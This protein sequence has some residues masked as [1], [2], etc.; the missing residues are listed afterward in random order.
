MHVRNDI[1][2]QFDIPKSG[3][4]HVDS[5]VIVSD[6]YKVEDVE[7]K[8]TPD[9]M[10]EFVGVEHTDPETLWDLMVA[11]IQGEETSNESVVETPVVAEPEV[12]M[13]TPSAVETPEPAEESKKPTRKT[14]S[15]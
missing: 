12:D 3:T 6:G 9:A 4:T 2:A 10:K 11:K 1:A 13:Q 15:K 8:L 7:A 5:N 14:K